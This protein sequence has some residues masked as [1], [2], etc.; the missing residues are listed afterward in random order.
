MLL[1]QRIQ[2]LM[3]TSTHQFYGNVIGDVVDGDD[4]SMPWREESSMR[5]RLLPC[6]MDKQN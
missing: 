6:Q 3:G 5:R 2:A 4:E 1:D